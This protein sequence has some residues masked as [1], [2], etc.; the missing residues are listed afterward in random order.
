MQFTVSAQPRREFLRAAGRCFALGFLALVGA[1]ALIRNRGDKCEPFP[2][3]QGCGVFETCSLPQALQQK[4][5]RE[6]RD[7]QA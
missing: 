4:P 7:G 3:C 5:N 6:R 1:I 2:L